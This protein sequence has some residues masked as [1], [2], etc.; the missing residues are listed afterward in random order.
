MSSQSA[1]VSKLFLTLSSSTAQ[2]ITDT[3]SLPASHPSHYFELTHLL[4]PQLV[5]LDD[6]PPPVSTTVRRS[7]ADFA[8]YHQD[9]F[10][11]DRAAGKFGDHLS[12]ITE[13]LRGSSSS[14]LV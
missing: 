8:R 7:A 3:V 12:E 13:W 2:L 1:I 5:H 4:P 14:Y 11:A 6:A 9:T 10:E